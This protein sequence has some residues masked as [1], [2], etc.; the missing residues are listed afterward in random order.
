MLYTTSTFIMSWV[1][2]RHLSKSGGNNIRYR[3]GQFNKRSS[4][5][6]K[7]CRHIS[8]CLIRSKKYKQFQE[9]MNYSHKQNVMHNLYSGLEEDPLCRM[10]AV[11][12]RELLALADKYKNKANCICGHCSICKQQRYAVFNKI[13]KIIF[14]NIRY[15]SMEVALMDTGEQTLIQ[16]IFKKIIYENDPY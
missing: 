5:A 15:R 3:I 8:T 7:T 13:Y 12:I 16:C 4:S 2:T 9:K 11:Y 6:Y 10:A 1:I 14:R